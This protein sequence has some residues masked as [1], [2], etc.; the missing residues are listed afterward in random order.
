MS[1]YR[2][3]CDDTAYLLKG[4]VNEENNHDPTVLTMNLSLGARADI[5]VQYYSTRLSPIDGNERGGS[6]VGEN[7]QRASIP[8]DRSSL[9]FISQN[10]H[11][12]RLK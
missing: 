2:E 8:T 12:V 9:A 1:M 10:L 7:S 5:C 11:N 6:A 3:I 4:F